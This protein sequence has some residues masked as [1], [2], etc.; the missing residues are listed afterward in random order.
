MGNNTQRIKYLA[1]N[2]AIFTFGNLGS[3]IISFFLIPLYTN[4]LTTE[5]YGV[6]DLIVTVVTVA[7]PILTL[8]INESVMRFSLDKD[9][10]TKKITQI[11]T[12]ILVIGMVVGLFI[13]PIC[14]SFDSISQYS[15]F[16]Y[17]YVISLAASQLY[18]CDL[19]GK[20]L[21]IYYSLGNVLNTLFIAV[22]NILFLLVFKKGIKGYLKAYIIANA[23]TAI[24]AIIVGKGYRSFSFSEIDKKLLHRMVKYSVVLIPNSF[25]WWIMN[26]SDRIMVSSMIGVAAN[27]IYAV[28]YKL[29]TLVSTLTTIFN[30][31][32]S[33]SAIREEG[34]SDESEYNNRVF[35][36]LI[37]I[38]M[39]IGIGLVTF[40]KPF[41][42]I[43]VAKEYYI[44]WKYTPFLTIG[45]VYL[46]MASF[47]ATSYTVHKDSFGYL[48]SG[49]FGAAFNIA[50]NFVLIPL[51]GVFGAA[52]AT[53]ISYILVFVFRLFHTR[54][55]I[56]YNIKNKE[57]L[58]GSL[59]LL[60]SACLMF[61]NNWIGF[62]LQYVLLLIAICLFSNTWY[63][64]VK[65]VLKFKGR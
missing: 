56:Q 42:S 46:T 32:W 33:Y 49:M 48:F 58:W 5:E 47:M 34:T 1:K 64:M 35:K 24:Y 54:K 60:L 43:Y 19:R 38:V 44:A 53:C 8:N 40:M 20:E 21:L 52:I 26:S 62:V 29:P 18:L 50:M 51:I 45:C 13:L 37:G 7:I 12:N 3:K 15:I 41:L 16:V 25:M 17:F 65:K 23:L 39:L 59:I 28:S 9:A 57:F 36:T 61:V 55:Y 2:T 11:G 6:I 63:P 30:Q 14:H 27:G 22:L 4:A 10:N 31:A